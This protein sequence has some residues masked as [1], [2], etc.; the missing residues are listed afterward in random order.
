MTKVDRF[1]GIFV[2]FKRSSIIKDVEEKSFKKLEF[3]GNSKKRKFERIV[4]LGRNKNPQNI[5]AVVK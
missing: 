5:L 2:G 1:G 4:K 3:F